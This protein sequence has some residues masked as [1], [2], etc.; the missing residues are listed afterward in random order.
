MVLLGPGRCLSFSLSAFC[1]HYRP[2]KKLLLLMFAVGAISVTASSTNILINCSFAPDGLGGVLDWSLRSMATSRIVRSIEN[3]PGGLPAYRIVFGKTDYLTQGRL[4]LMAGEAY[5][6]LAWVRTKV[7]AGDVRFYCTDKADA[8]T[9]LFK[10]C[11]G[12]SYNASMGS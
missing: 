9:L 11:M 3:G 8:V 6:V 2:M 5:E 4:S 12:R 1:G 7:L 10:C